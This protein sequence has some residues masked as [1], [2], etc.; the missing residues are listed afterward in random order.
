MP[1]EGTRSATGNSRP[2]VF[3]TVDTAP[4]INRRKPAVGRTMKASTA[5]NGS[6]TKA[7]AKAKAATGP[8]S[9][10]VTKK[11]AAPKKATA[12]SKAKAAVNKAEA[13]VKGKTAP[14]DKA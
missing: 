3:Q 7:K 5:G 4:T 2:R 8:R 12:G 6:V 10:G 9:A 14:K 13:K 1:R 11:K